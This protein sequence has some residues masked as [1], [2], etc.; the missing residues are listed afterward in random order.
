MEYFVFFIIAWMIVVVIMWLVV[1]RFKPQWIGLGKDF[2]DQKIDDVRYHY[3][4]CP[5]CNTG[6]MEPTFDM[7][8]FSLTRR[9]IGEP[10]YPKEYVCSNCGSILNGHYFGEKITQSLVS[11]IPTEKAIGSIILFL[12][13]MFCV[14]I[15]EVFF[16]R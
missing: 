3:H 12:F 14:F 1:R 9:Y 4:K 7:R 16:S 5:N 2:N 11:R 6:R 8:L 15:Y 13:I 10:C